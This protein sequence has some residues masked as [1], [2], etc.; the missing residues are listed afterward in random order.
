MIDALAAIVILSAANAGVTLI[1]NEST[2]FESVREWA[3]EP[4][5]ELLHCPVCLGTWVGAAEAAAVVY[6]LGFGWTFDALLAGVV[7]TFA[8]MMGG[9]LFRKAWF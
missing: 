5:K 7:I 8:S 6:E 9:L 1:V 2:L 4:L 3:R